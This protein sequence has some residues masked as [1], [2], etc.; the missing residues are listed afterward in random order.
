MKLTFSLFSQKL[1]KEV[2]TSWFKVKTLNIVLPTFANIIN[3]IDLN[4]NLSLLSLKINLLSKW[5][6]MVNTFVYLKIWVM[7]LNK[8]VFCFEMPL[9]L[10]LKMEA[11][12]SL[13]PES[14]WEFQLEIW[15]LLHLWNPRNLRHIFL[16]F[17]FLGSNSRVESRS[18]WWILG[19]F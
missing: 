15:T 17:V 4:K 16:R 13:R 19:P 7:S 11:V 1:K 12:L 14:Y 2:K 3:Q 5:W 6:N 8:E 10:K 18:F 9:K